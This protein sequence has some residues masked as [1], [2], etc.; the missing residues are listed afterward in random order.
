MKRLFLLVSALSLMLNVQLYA[1]LD[2]ETLSDKG[3]G[4]D[5]PAGSNG[6]TIY[7]TNLKAKGP[8]SFRAAVEATGPRTIVFE[9]GGIIDLK[10]QTIVISE[11]FV[12]IDGLS[13][14]R[15]GITFIRGGISI[16]T[17][18]VLIR[19]IRVRPGDAGMGKRSGWS[20]DGISTSA[21]YNVV[22]DHCS[23]TWAVDENLSVSGPRLEGPEA[24]SHDVTVSHCIIAEGLH[25]SSHE[26]GP[27]SKGTL[28]HD[29]CRNI[30]V[31]GNLYAH[32]VERNP[33]FKAFTT[34]VVVNNL[35]YNPGRRAIKVTYADSEWE[36]VPIE[37]QNCKIAVVGNVLIHGV[38]SR[39]DLP[40]VSN[41][42]DVYL[43]NNIALDRNGNPVPMTEGKIN[44]LEEKPVWPDGLKALPA[45]HVIDYIVRNVGAR[46][47]ERDSVDRRIIDDF[48]QRKGR[49]IDS[50]DEVG[51]YPTRSA[52]ERSEKLK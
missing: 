2:H 8:G 18:D 15:P 34:G 14:P 10:K 40:L 45:A 36:D 28:I 26:K 6:R 39:G 29:Y 33:Y 11:P 3:F 9:I 24:T 25:D 12:T 32:N 16:R 5:T 23:T 44:I 21:A 50:Q 35:I 17:H 27:H 20:P 47:D 19:H 49:I 41:R 30:A 37:P 51:G 7:V 1:A 42:G 22:I 13:A 46:P 43:E 48:L 38:D 52:H 4:I 31:I